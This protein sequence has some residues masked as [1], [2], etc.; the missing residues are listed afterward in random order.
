MINYNQFKSMFT[1]SDLILAFLIILIIALMVVPIPAPLLD[2]LMALN[3]ALS[4]MVLLVAMYL[5]EPLDFAAFPSLLL[6]F[7]L[8]RLSLN[9]SS[10]KLILALGADFDGKV[11]EAFAEFVTRG[12]FV[13]GLV[14]FAIITLVQF[15]VVTKGSERVAEVAARFTLDALPGKQMSIDADLNAGLID[16]EE[17]KGRRDK[18]SKESNFFGSMDGANKFVKGDAIAGIVIVII[19][20]VGGLIIGSFQQGM[21]FSDALTTFAR[22]TVGDGLV[23]QL[24]ALLIAI[25]TG[26]VVTKS[27]SKESLGADVKD[28][29]F[30][31]PKAFAVTSTILLLI[32][33]VPGLPTLPFMFLSALA[34][35]IAIYILYSKQAEEELAIDSSQE[36]SKDALKKPENLLNTLSLDPI[37]LKTGR[38]LVPLIDPNNN[39]PLLERVTLVRYHIGQELGFVIPGVRVMDELSLPPNQYL[40]EIRGSR[41]AVGEALL[42]HVFVSRPVTDLVQ[43]GLDIV[44]ALDPVSNQSG[45]WISDD[46]IGVLQDNAVPFSTVTDFIAD[47]FSDAIKNHS[48]EI[49][50]RQNVQSLI[51]LVKNSNAAIVR[52]LVPDMLSLGQVHK[53]LQMLV[54][55]RVSIRDLSTILEKLAD[56]SQV[57]RDT[58]LLSEYVRQ[59]LSRQLSRQFSDKEDV[60]TVFTIN[61]R[62]EETM[63]NS[64]HQSEY[65]SFLALEP[66]LGEDVLSQ[67]KEFMTSFSRMDKQPV[68]LCSPRLRTHF[69]RFTERNYPNLSV[70]SYNEVIPQVKVQSIGVVDS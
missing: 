6:I 5:S 3:I 22:F 29:I 67:I 49:M 59:S 25:A 66:Q 16:A 46:Q 30:S 64:I 61:P 19:N 2:V 55:E 54:K 40:V 45:A 24:P 20:I 33:I 52:E 48:D 7:T 65:G 50:T 37:S 8:F 47:H 43:L 70:L 10:T 62:L 4:I 18:L 58:T 32:S 42:G 51:E 57:S 23:S 60:L 11:I 69:K 14:A 31:Q 68:S 26:L 35:G 27:A 41:V 28:Q 63:I 12:N 15:M 38:N 36:S 9:V 21:S 17:A 53:V 13:V 39:G 1:P 34:G 44:E 56:Y